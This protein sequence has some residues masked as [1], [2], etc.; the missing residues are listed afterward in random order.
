MDVQSFRQETIS[1]VP[2]LIQSRLPSFAETHNKNVPKT[3]DT[4]YCFPDTEY[5]PLEEFHG[6]LTF[7]IS[8]PTKTRPQAILHAPP[9]MSN[10]LRSLM[11][12]GNALR[13]YLA[14]SHS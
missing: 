1:L 13:L 10:C 8:H 3:Y 6:I 11:L 14:L 5:M 7:P 12:P 4:R 9:D 2:T